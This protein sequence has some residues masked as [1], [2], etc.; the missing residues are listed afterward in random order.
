MTFQAELKQ[1]KEELED[2]VKLLKITRSQLEALE[3]PC[4]TAI[5]SQFSKSKMTSVIL[6][7]IAS[8]WLA[9]NAQDYERMQALPEESRRVNLDLMKKMVDLK[10]KYAKKSAEDKGKEQ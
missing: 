5:G 7:T 6:T 10:A 1:T 8:N 2:F 9:I 4:R 3:Q